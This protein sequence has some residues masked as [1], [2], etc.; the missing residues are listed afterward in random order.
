MAGVERHWRA[1]SA[2]RVMPWK[3]GL[4]ETLEVARFPEGESLDA[5]DWRVSVAPVIADGAFSVFPGIERTIAVIEGAGM[6]LT[7]AGG[8]PYALLPGMPYTYDGGLAIDGRL[9]DGPVRD[10]NVMARRGRFTGELILAG[11]PLAV[12]GS[13]ATIVA[14]ALQGVWRMTLDAEAGRL[15]PGGSVTT[16]AAMLSADPRSPGARLAVALLRAE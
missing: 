11:G 14:Y 13:G 3:N 2:H 10:F 4:G 8:R 15:E 6:E 7:L 16:D 12:A 1:A 5:F 9:I